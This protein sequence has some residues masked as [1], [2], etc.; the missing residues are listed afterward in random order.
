MQIL[1]NILFHVSLKKWSQIGFEL[2]EGETIM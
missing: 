1:E 2:H